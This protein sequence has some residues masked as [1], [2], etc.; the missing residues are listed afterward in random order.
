MKK[1]DNSDSR[2]RVLKMNPV[3]IKTLFPLSEEEKRGLCKKT[4]PEE[5]NTHKTN[6]LLDIIKKQED[7]INLSFD[8]IRKQQAEINELKKAALEVTAL[9]NELT[10]LK[11]K[12]KNLLKETDES[13]FKTECRNGKASIINYIENDS[14]IK[15]VVIP[16]YFGRNEVTEIGNS[17]FSS[18]KQLTRIIIP[19]SVTYIGERAF[20]ECSSLISLTIPYGLASIGSN[21][22]Y[23][24]SS[25]NSVTIPDSV[26]SIGESAFWGCSSLT[27]ITIPYGLKII[28][29]N[30]F[31]RCSSLNSVIIPDTLTSIGDWAFS[32]CRSLKSITIPD[33]VIRIGEW[34]FY[35]CSKLTFYCSK[36][37]YA[38]TYAKKKGIRVRNI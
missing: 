17:A 13:M 16:M 30:A 33:S 35:E 15:E 6:E 38:N 31:N 21:A 37:S 12:M 25:L 10:V 20:F 23:G 29:T 4:D 36:K 14:G 19:D 18:C 2:K 32:G 1:D 22:F 26:E 3:E 24:C 27:N 7:R 28:G 11:S 34:A 8:L 9:K 5:P